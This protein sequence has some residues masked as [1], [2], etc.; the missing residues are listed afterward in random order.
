MEF[1][2]YLKNKKME[3]LRYPI[4][5][6]EFKPFSNDIKNEW[7]LDMKSL[8]NDDASNAVIISMADIIRANR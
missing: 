6:F 8:P 7:L 3:D 4:G 5:N 1:L 2:T